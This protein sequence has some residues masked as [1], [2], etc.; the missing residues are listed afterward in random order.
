MI[1]FSVVVQS[2]VVQHSAMKWE[3]PHK[4]KRPNEIKISKPHFN[5]FITFNEC[6]QHSQRFIE[7]TYTQTLNRRMNFLEQATH[8]V[9]STCVRLKIKISFMSTHDVTVKLFALCFHSLLFHQHKKL[10]ADV[11]MCLIDVPFAVVDVFFSKP[12]KSAL[13]SF[14]SCHVLI[15]SMASGCNRII[16]YSFSVGCA[17]MCIW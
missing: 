3:K 6:I 5:S 1:I 8:F 13:F 12:K 17:C 16:S 9:W 7:P 11:C 2:V 14:G 10:Y 4:K 15:N